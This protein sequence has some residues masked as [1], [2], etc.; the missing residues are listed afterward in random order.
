MLP[1]GNHLRLHP[2]ARDVRAASRGKHPSQR[3]LERQ[4][5]FREPDLVTKAPE[6]FEDAAFVSTSSRLKKQDVLGACLRTSSVFVTLGTSGS[7]LLPLAAR[8]LSIP[9]S[10]HGFESVQTI[11]S[12]S[13]AFLAVAAGLLVTISRMALIAAWPALRESN[14]TGNSQVWFD[15]TWS[16]IFLMECICFW[17]CLDFFVACNRNVGIDR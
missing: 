9:M 1:F 4:S 2:A 6:F 17:L 14:E 5:A 11:P 8:A 13:G 16:Q 7:V 12:I 3:A 10:M 15:S